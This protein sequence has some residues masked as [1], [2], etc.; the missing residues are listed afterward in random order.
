MKFMTGL[1]KPDCSAMLALT[2]RRIAD[3][4]GCGGDDH[5]DRA[6]PALRIAVLTAA[7]ACCLA[8]SRNPCRCG[9]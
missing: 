7:L 9:S 6:G 1:A 3:R 5:R 8:S 4:I 2:I